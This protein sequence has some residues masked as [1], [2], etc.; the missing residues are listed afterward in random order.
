MVQK[1]GK[2]IREGGA[3]R[4]SYQLHSG[5]LIRITVTPLSQSI[6]PFQSN[7]F[8]TTY[9]HLFH[10]PSTPLFIMTGSSLMVR[11]LPLLSLA[12]A[13]SS[14]SPSNAS[15]VIPDFTQRD[16]PTQSQRDRAHSIHS[17]SHQDYFKSPLN[18]RKSL[19]FGPHHSH[20]VFVS[21][22]AQ[23][24]QGE[25]STSSTGIH[26]NSIH[27]VNAL[28]GSKKPESSFTPR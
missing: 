10:S 14:I 1:E 5:R 3:L 12:F 17:H 25:F 9:L 27:T 7:A 24:H 16:A 13:I 22:S 6:Q 11:L 2:N 4:A 21:D 18:H 28:P 20:Q 19:G 23:S 26:S 15:L 8:S